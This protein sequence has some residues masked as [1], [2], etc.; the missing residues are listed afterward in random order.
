M[1]DLQTFNFSTSTQF[2]YLGPTV[3][4]RAATSW[5]FRREGNDYNFMLYA[6]TKFVFENFGRNCPVAPWLW[7]W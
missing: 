6:T 2:H 1:L 3:G 7:T 4:S 5:Y